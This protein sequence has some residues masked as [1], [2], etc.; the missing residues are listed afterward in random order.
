LVEYIYIYEFFLSGKWIPSVVS[1]EELL[2]A[3][4][5]LIEIASLD[6]RVQVLGGVVIFDMEGLGMAHAW[7]M[8]PT[9][10]QKLLEIMV[11]CD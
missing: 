6:P 4:M 11:V 10:A 8:S 3:T 2:Q 9:V 7:Q 5:I 1:M